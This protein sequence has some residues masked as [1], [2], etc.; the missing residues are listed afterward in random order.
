M[1]FTCIQAVVM[2]ALIAIMAIQGG[3]LLPFVHVTFKDVFAVFARIKNATPW[4]S[5]QI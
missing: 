5:A 3:S 2:C 1:A 4:R